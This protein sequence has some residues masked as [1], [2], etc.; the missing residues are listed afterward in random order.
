MN[1]GLIA[2][3]G[4]FSSIDRKQDEHWSTIAVCNSTM[5]EEHSVKQEEIGSVLTVIKNFMEQQTSIQMDTA[6]RW[7]IE[8]HDYQVGERYLKILEGRTGVPGVCN[9]DA[10]DKPRVRNA[11]SQ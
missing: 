9:E 1:A 3:Q 2:L 8:E 6:Q 10:A 7:S 5:I 4:V 11:D